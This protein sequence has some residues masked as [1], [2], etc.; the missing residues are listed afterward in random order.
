MNIAS[1]FSGAGG[2]DL[3]FEKAGFNVVWANEFDKT[4]W[5]TY[6]KNFPDTILDKRSI[7]DID[8][9]DLPIVDGIIGGPPC[10]S[11]SIAGSKKGIEDP[12][13]KLF[14]EFMRILEEREPK[15][16][17]AENV[18]GMLTEKNKPAL[19][20]LKEM[21]KDIGYNLSFTPVDA[22]DYN[23]PQN[24]KRVFLLGIDMIWVKNSLFQ[25][26]IKENQF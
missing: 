7:T 22:W 10:Q 17:V 11:W 2:M 14:F 12:R 13:G 1:F 25:K 21:F 3:G 26:K 8:A 20:R 6:Q 9:W 18:S 23:V 16:F 4:I 15:F 19:E 24:R 5:E